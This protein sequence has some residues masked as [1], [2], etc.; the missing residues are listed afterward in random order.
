MTFNKFWVLLVL[1]FLYFFCFFKIVL[2]AQ[3][4]N[5]SHDKKKQEKK[6]KSTLHARENT[7]EQ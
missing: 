2:C 5:L 4:V 7:K 3:L 6:K 1:V